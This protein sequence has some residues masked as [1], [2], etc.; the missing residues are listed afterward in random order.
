MLTAELINQI[1]Q[2]LLAIFILENLI[3]HWLTVAH[4]HGD[5]CPI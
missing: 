2:L 5:L 3:E 4:I 1:P